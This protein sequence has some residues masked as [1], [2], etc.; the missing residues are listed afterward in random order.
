MGLAA[1]CGLLKDFFVLITQHRLQHWILLMADLYLRRS[2]VLK[3]GCILSPRRGD[4]ICIFMGTISRGSGLFILA[5]VP[6]I[7]FIVIYFNMIS[8]LQKLCKNICRMFIHLDLSDASSWINPG[9]PFWGQKYHRNDYLLVSS[10]VLSG[11]IQFLCVQL[12]IT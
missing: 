12:F 9:Y 8:I 1:G 6:G 10:L 5:W 2:A 3:S 4:L 7:C 11:A